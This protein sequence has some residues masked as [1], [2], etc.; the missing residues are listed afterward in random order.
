MFW[1]YDEI[2]SHRLVRF[3]DGDSE[4]D[5]EQSFAAGR[6]EPKG[7]VEVLPEVSALD[8]SWSALDGQH[9]AVR[10]GIVAKGRHGSDWRMCLRGVGSK[11]G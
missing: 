11:Y 4:A 1:A 5:A 7:K 6:V 9:A 2:E 8:Y 3:F 10:P